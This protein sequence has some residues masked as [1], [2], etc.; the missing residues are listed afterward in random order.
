MNKSYIRYCRRGVPVVTKFSA[1]CSCVNNFLT[2]LWAQS[3]Q[4]QVHSERAV[5]NEPVD[6][7]YSVRI[8]LYVTELC[9]WMGVELTY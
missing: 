2:R 3:P 1:T 9:H 6:P 4:N 7:R 5:E 8:S